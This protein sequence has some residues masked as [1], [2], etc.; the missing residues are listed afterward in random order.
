MQL[1]L[2][3][4]SNTVVYFN[5]DTETDIILYSGD[6]LND[7]KAWIENNYPGMVIFDE[8]DDYI[9]Y[10]GKGNPPK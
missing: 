6:S 8:C 3:L 1:S 2:M 9:G 10:D 4:D 7:A 5:A